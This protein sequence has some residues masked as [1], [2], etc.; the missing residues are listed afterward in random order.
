MTSDE[1]LYRQYQKGNEDAAAE[2]VERY[3]DSLILYITGF[4]GDVYEA[5]DLM[6]EAFSLMF[7]KNRPVE[8]EGSF[9]A[10]LYK[11][12]R[13]LAIKHY[14]KE[15]RI[16]GFCDLNFELK[17]DDFTDM[18]LLVHE[19][20]KT[21]Y[22]AMDRLKQE[23]KEALFLVYF[24]ELSYKNAAKIMNKT[25]SQITKLVYRGKQNLK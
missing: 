1:L 14:K 25:E 23:Y 21:L 2:L 12:A 7:A 8:H 13:N 11:I 17:S 19:R 9:R 3:G 20:M 24:E 6:I 16:I 4:I 10:Y 18:P 22:A 15:N 5:E